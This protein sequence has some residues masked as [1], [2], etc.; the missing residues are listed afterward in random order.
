MKQ[1]LP[2]THDT[3]EKHGLLK[4]IIGGDNTVYHTPVLQKK[5]SEEAKDKERKTRVDHLLNSRKSPLKLIF[6]IVIISLILTGLYYL[7]THF[8][9]AG[10]ITELFQQVKNTLPT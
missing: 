3:N 8:G 2:T 9:V 1:V 4:K 6:K 5:L 10:K 7:F